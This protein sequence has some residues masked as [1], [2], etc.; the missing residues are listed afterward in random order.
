MGPHRRARPST[1]VEM[2]QRKDR[3]TV[4]VLVVLV[5]SLGLGCARDLTTLAARTPPR[6]GRG[7]VPARADLLCG[8]WRRAVDYDRDASSHTSFPELDTAR[9]CYVE[10][11]HDERGL[12]AGPVPAGCGFPSDVA[13]SRTHLL[14][15]AALYDRVAQGDLAVLPR[16]LACSLPPHVRESAARHNAAVFRALSAIETPRRYPYAAALVPGYGA[17]R[18]DTSVL[19]GAKPGDTCRALDAAELEK[20]GVNVLRAERGAAVVRDGVAPVL[21][22]SGGAVHSDLVEA[23]ALEHVA[24]C[25]FG[26]PASRIVVDPC[27][28]HTHT[29]LRNAGA[30]VVGLGARVAYL[31]TDPHLQSDYLGDF[32]AFDAIGG[33]VDQRSLRDFGYLVGAWRR[34]S[35]GALGGFWYTPYRFWGDEGPL[36]DATCLTDV[37]APRP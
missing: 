28:D 25:R 36:R 3:G 16:E 29:N 23:F 12:R 4:S 14:G 27:A 10:V 18:Q 6:L 11:S 33:S 5:A 37:V 15:R 8:E 19:V 32:M 13:T 31:V 30:V 2:T 1:L 21:V 34:A 35:R 24:R 17:L 7:P 20:L 26:I 9:S 22:V